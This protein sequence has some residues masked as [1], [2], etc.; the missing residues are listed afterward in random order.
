MI[1]DLRRVSMLLHIDTDTWFVV[2]SAFDIFDIVDDSPNVLFSSCDKN[3]V[4][5]SDGCF[6]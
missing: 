1:D 5:V 3:V 6:S 4:V 2:A